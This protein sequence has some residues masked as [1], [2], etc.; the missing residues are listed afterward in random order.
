MTAPKLSIGVQA[1]RSP[2]S[3]GTSAPPSSS[4]AVT[5]PEARASRVRGNA[6]LVELKVHVQLGAERVGAAIDRVRGVQR[7]VL[8][9]RGRERRLVLAR[10]RGERPAVV[11]VAP[12]LGLADDEPRAARWRQL[13]VHRRRPADGLH[14][15]RVE[16]R[17]ERVPPGRV[18]AQVEPLGDGRAQQHAAPVAAL[19]QRAG[20]PLEREADVLGVV[21]QLVAPRDAAA[22]EDFFS[23]PALVD[24]A[25]ARRRELEARLRKHNAA[26]REGEDGARRSSSCHRPHGSD[27][28]G[29][30]YGFCPGATT[31]ADVRPDRA[32][33]P[34]H[35]GRR[36]TTDMP[37][38]RDVSFAGVGRSS[39]ATRGAARVP[40]GVGCRRRGRTRP[41]HSSSAQPARWGSACAPRSSLAGTA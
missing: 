22:D 41:R 16:L 14:R 29:R 34:D 33:E 8:E 17:A 15:R 19:E 28:K 21:R 25:V 35:A 20:R 7:R 18:R 5:K 11:A 37:H 40:R 1:M 31:G 23:D 9:R 12:A 13:E 2:A 27:R 26:Q 32:T 4:S 10:D 3:L 39:A 6:R 38:L 24:R 36:P 30:F